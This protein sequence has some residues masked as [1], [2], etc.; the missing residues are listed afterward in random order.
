[1]IR[2]RGEYVDGECWRLGALKRATDFREPLEIYMKIFYI[3]KLLS[4]HAIVSLSFL[5]AAC[6]LFNTVQYRAG[7]CAHCSSKRQQ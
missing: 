6:F 7:H 2:K 4:L 3:S 1:M 5:I